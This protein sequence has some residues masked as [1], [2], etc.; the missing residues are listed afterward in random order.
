MLWKHLFVG[1]YLYVDIS[2]QWTGDLEPGLTTH[3]ISPPFH[4]SLFGVRKC[5]A[6]LVNAYGPHVGGL[7]VL[8]ERGRYVK[9]Y[10]GDEK[11]ALLKDWF[12]WSTQL[13][14][15]QVLFVLEA[16]KGGTVAADD[17]GDICVDDVVVFEGAC[18]EKHPSFSIQNSVIANSLFVFMLFFF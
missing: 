6:M 16:T 14:P 2:S 18:G 9:K 11:N 7:A 4:E 1:N 5:L 3:A 10:I 13:F 8:D 12:V 17:K 15:E